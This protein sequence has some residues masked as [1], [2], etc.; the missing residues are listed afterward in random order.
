VIHDDAGRV[1]RLD[2]IVTD[3]TELN[4][5]QDALRENTSRLQGLT[6]HL[7]SVREEQSARI[8]REVHDELAAR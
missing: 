6:A 8:A 1:A 4:R 2:G 5:V 7:E 3:M